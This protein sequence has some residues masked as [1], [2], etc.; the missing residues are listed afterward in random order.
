M[1]LNGIYFRGPQILVSM[2]WDQSK[3]C[4][5]LKTWILPAAW[6]PGTKRI[7][8]EQT[9]R[10]AKE[11]WSKWR[12]GGQTRTRRNRDGGRRPSLCRKVCSS[13]R[14]CRRRRWAARSRRRRFCRRCCSR[15]SRPW[16]T[17]RIPG[18]TR[19]HSKND[20]NNLSSLNSFSVKYFKLWI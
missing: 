19:I 6:Q 13:T 9:R 4:K 10:K 17:E 5:K 3:K 11:F 2:K 14:T 7:L 1:T 18:E 16:T 12:I 20:E 15:R 8:P